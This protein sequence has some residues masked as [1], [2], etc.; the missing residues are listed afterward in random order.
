MNIQ[1]KAINSLKISVI[2]PV[3]NA[4]PYLNRC[5]NSVLAQ[6]YTNW[7]MILVDDGSKDKS[8]V[9]IDEA[10]AKDDRLVSIHQANAG[11]GEARNTG[12]SAATGDYVVFLDSDDYI[13]NEYFSL[14]IPKAETNDVVFVDVRQ[15]DGE[16]KEICDESVSKY[17]SETKDFF[18]RSQMTGKIS[19]GGYRKAA[20]LNLIRKHNIHYTNHKI[21][22]EALYS[23]QLLSAAERI[24]FLDEKPVYFYV[25][26]DDSLSKSRDIDPWGGAAEVL[27][28]F[29]KNRGIYGV[30]G[31][32]VNTFRVTALIVSLDRIT[33]YYKG[34]ERRAE[35][36]KR[37]KCFKNNF[38]SQIAIDTKSMS[39][40]VRVFLPFIRRGIVF[41]VVWASGMRQIV[42]NGVRKQRT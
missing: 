22:E 36:N 34:A 8:A 6:T 17:K 14:L 15:V 4:E 33:Q 29:V 27:A 41:P 18:V 16:G 42:K 31:N 1:D 30:Y 32:T 20:S 13:D 21:G 7:E 3:Y 9:L 23:F 38:D 10:A 24:G 2:V 5:I 35:I 40:K 25:N 26:R 37:M 12:L 39:Y 19:W 28:D 11:A